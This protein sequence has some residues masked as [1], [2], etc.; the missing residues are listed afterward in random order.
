MPTGDHI[1][2]ADDE[3]LVR[4]LATTILEA[5]GYRVTAFDDGAPALAALLADGADFAALVTDCRMTRVSGPEVL[6]R[7]RAAGSE[8][9]VLLSSGSE[10]PSSIPGLGADPKAAFLAKPFNRAQLV[11]VIGTL[12]SSSP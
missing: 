11:A 12:L 8:L 5:A 9:P 2:V 1:V 10:P 7:L 4:A 3:P 6:A